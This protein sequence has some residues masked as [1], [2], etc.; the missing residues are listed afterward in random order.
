[1]KNGNCEKSPIS[2][3]IIEPIIKSNIKYVENIEE[4]EKIQLQVNET[5]LCFDNNEPC[6]Y[7]RERNKFGEFLPTQ[8]YFYE[9]FAEKVKSIERGEFVEKCRNAGLDELKTEVA[10][11]FFLENKKPQEVWLWAISEK[12]KDWEWDYVR[13][14]KYKLK[15][16]LFKKVT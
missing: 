12:G 14:L 8:I 3:D 1:M 7:I 6:F 13:G 10:I 16:K 9:N 15:I 2:K 5:I 4:F 11:M